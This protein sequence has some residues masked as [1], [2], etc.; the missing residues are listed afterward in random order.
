MNLHLAMPSAGVHKGRLA[1][2]PTRAW[3]ASEENAK[4]QAAKIIQVSMAGRQV[5]RPMSNQRNST[6]RFVT[7]VCY[8]SLHLPNVN[9]LKSNGFEM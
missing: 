8:H 1:E 6:S 3:Q 4:F 2:R 7:R 5:V 9:L